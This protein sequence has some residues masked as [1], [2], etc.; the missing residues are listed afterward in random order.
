MDETSAARI[1]ISAIA[2][3]EPPWVL[4]N[5]WFGE[6]IP[7]KFV[8]HTGI[9]SRSISLEDEVTMGV[10]VVRN[11]QRETGCDLNDCAALVFVSPSFVP[12]SVAR[13][14]LDENPNLPATS[15][16]WRG[17]GAGQAVSSPT[18]RRTSRSVRI[19]TREP[20]APNCSAKAPMVQRPPREFASSPAA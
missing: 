20:P 18:A 13:R 4:G 1:G 3:Y 12:V 7:R 15:S 11:L 14:Y 17:C 6:T 5:D 16:I 19:P 2:T 9:E 10:R 8:H